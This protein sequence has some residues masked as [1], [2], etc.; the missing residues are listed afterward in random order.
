TSRGQSQALRRR[1]ANNKGGHAEKGNGPS[2]FGHRESIVS[3]IHGFYPRRQKFGLKS[4]EPAV[5]LAGCSFSRATCQ[6]TATGSRVPVE[7]TCDI[8]D[9]FFRRRAIFFVNFACNPIRERIT[10]VKLGRFL[11]H[12]TMTHNRGFCVPL[13]AVAAIFLV[14]SNRARADCGDYV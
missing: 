3:G 10:W 5:D 11:A 9:N 14:A 12:L 4:S 7:R 1:E 6:F 2:K 8:A 13:L